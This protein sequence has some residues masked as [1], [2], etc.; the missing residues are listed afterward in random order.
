MDSD[1]FIFSDQQIKGYKTQMMDWYKWLI[2]H[3]YDHPDY[4]AVDS[5]QIIG[6]AERVRTPILIL[7]DPKV[8]EFL[9]D[10]ICQIQISLLED[11]WTI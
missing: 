5:G 4:L 2:S 6:I 1:C 11:Y 3:Q 7:C 8:L 9:T 10:F